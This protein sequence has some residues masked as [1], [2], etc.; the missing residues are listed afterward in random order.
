M[1]FYFSK[2]YFLFGFEHFRYMYLR[3][4]MDNS[5]IILNFK[6]YISFFFFFCKKIHDSQGVFLSK[7]YVVFILPHFTIFHFSLQFYGCLLLK[8]WLHYFFLQ[9]TTYVYFCQF[10]SLI[11]TL[12]VLYL[13]FIRRRHA[14]CLTTRLFLLY[15]GHNCGYLAFWLLD[16]ELIL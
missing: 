11:S 8:Y 3:T 13:I 6:F 12:Y 10:L 16:T 15:T 5:N 2:D 9:C 4:K 14:Y 7:K 1:H